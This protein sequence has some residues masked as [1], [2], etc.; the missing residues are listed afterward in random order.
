MTS[1]KWAGRDDGE[2]GLAARRVYHCCAESGRHAILGFCSDEGV[3]RNQ[4]RTGA[5]HGPDAIR[6]ALSNLP[7]P[8][9]FPTFTDV[10]NICVTD[11][12]LEYAQERLRDAIAL[13]LTNHEAVLVLGGGHETAYGSYQGVRA[14]NP[15]ARIGILN[16]DAHLDIRNIGPNG[17]SSG[18]PF[19][20]IRALDPTGFDYLCIGVAAE[21]NT[22]ALFNRA[23]EW[24]IK[25]VSDQEVLETRNTAFSEIDALVKR[26]DLI[27]LTIDLDVLPH[28]QAP[29][30]S[31]PAVRGIELSV[32]QSFIKHCLSSAKFNQCTLPVCDIVELC[33]DHDP[34]GMT[35]K[36]AAILANQLLQR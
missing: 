15:A 3:R 20:Q 29:G 10:G 31:C 21:S 8:P 4:G 36:T 30:V 35:A 32:L 6:K 18:T 26:N 22:Q 16:F 27:Y 23:A 12:N 13:A 19:N 9:D 34:Q 1:F 25:I 24:G 11:N 28:Y 14:A 33:P 7:I 17:P 5:R 2:D